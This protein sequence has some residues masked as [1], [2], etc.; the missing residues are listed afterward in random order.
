MATL[1]R[2]FGLILFSPGDAEVKQHAVPFFQTLLDKQDELHTIITTTNDHVQ[3]QGYHI[4]VEKKDNASHLFF[5]LDGRK[6]VM[7][8]GDDFLVGVKSYGKNQLAQDISKSPDGAS[9]DV[10][11]RPL[12]QSY[13]FPVVAQKG[14]PAE[15]AYFAQIN[16]I[17]QLFGLVPPYYQARPSATFVEKRFAELMAEHEIT[18]EELTGDIEQVINRVLAT[19]FPENLEKRFDQLKHDVDSRF[20][21]FVEESLQ[22][23]P[24]LSQFASQT[25]RKIDFTLKQFESK[26]FST[27]KKKSQQTRDRIYR[28]WHALYPNRALQ[29]RSLNI[30][31][32]LSRYGFDFIRFMYDKIDCE[33]NAHQIVHLTEMTS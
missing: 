7:R 9:P 5:N 25:Y 14:G 13:L 20:S 26:V 18:F 28:L 30:S 2:D 29:E 27:H 8:N 12:F 11:L 22:F 33:E 1:T 4:Q 24:S 17:F 3:E 23:D 19:S 16:P 32:F 6:P 31:Y 15:I 21:E 10:L